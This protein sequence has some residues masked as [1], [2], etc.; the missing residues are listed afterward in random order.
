VLS[1]LKGLGVTDRDTHMRV[2]REALVN[3]PHCLGVWA[4]WEPDAL[5]GCDEAF[6]NRKSHEAT[7]RFKPFWHRRLGEPTLEMNQHCDDPVLGTYYQRPILKRRPV[8][9][10]PY[11]YPVGG[12]KALLATVAAPIL[13]DNRCLGAAGVDFDLGAVIDH[14]ASEPTHEALEQLHR[15]GAELEA[16]IMILDR[17]HRLVAMSS[18]TLSLLDGFVMRP[19]P[20]GEPLPQDLQPREPATSGAPME[21]VLKHRGAQLTVVHATAPNERTPVVVVVSRC[22]VDPEITPLSSREDEVMH[23]LAEGKT[24]EEIGIILSI[25]SHTVKN[26][27]DRIYRKIGVDNRHAAMLAWSRAK[28]LTGAVSCP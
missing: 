13:W 28:A 9:V 11:C 14:L 6:V 22:V 16:G 24:N 19:M 25:S 21:L 1:V 8:I 4:V 2:L 7:G 12:S 17:G 15:I 27:L 5:D 18:S 3:H 23:W 10:A 26:H 20:F